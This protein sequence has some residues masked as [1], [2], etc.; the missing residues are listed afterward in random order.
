MSLLLKILLIGALILAIPSYFFGRHLYTHSTAYL[1]AK[2]DRAA[3][4]GKHDE[5]ERLAKLLEKKGELQAAHLL[6]GE[7]FVYLGIVASDITPPPDPYEDLQRA[8]QMV[9]GSA[10]LDSQALAGRPI[11]WTFASWHQ[12]SH[13][14]SSPALTAYRRALGELAQIQDDGPIGLRGT[15][16]AAECLIHLEE[17][18][19]AEEGLKALLKRYPDNKDAH[20]FLSVI[21]IDL[22]SPIEAVKH[23]EEWARLDPANG[24]PYRWIGFF[25]RDNQQVGEAIDGYEQALKRRLPPHVRADAIKELAEIF[26]SEGQSPKALETLALGSDSFQ[27][28]PEILALRVNCLRNIV[29]R[30]QEAV[31]LVD[32]SLQ[33]NPNHPKILFLRAQIFENEDK[34]DKALPLLEKAIK[35]DPYDLSTLTL[36]MKVYGELGRKEQADKFKVQVNEV[37]EILTRLA[38]LKSEANSRLWDDNVRLEIAVLALRINQP[39]QARTWAQAALSCNPGNSKARRL[40]N[41]LPTKEKARSSLDSTVADKK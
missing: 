23:L 17:K 10:G 6:R 36:L 38:T 11:L 19:L 1:L 22:N 12:E 27:N 35:I 26:H 30:E 33:K 7:D 18:R 40:L 9:G 32:S 5:V 24:L 13:R 37:Q 16:L 3:E 25:K 2:G 39:D 4:E 29:S 34:P 20:R 15:L 41:Q 31:E 28:D 21:Y 14:V 8:S